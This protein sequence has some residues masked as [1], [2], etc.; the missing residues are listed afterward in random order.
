MKKEERK[1]LKKDLKHP[2]TL[3]KGYQESDIV[4]FLILTK[5]LTKNTIIQ[6]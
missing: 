1:Q 2:I 5:V 4:P 6:K 3:L